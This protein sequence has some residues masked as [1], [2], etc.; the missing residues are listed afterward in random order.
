MRHR[1][2][3]ILALLAL[4]FA[5][6]AY[7]T[8]VCSADWS[9]TDASNNVASPR[10]FPE[11]MAPSGVNDSARA[12]MGAVKRF[13]NR[14][15]GVKTTGGTA[16]AQT[17]TYDVAAAAYCTGERFTFKA[18]AT[19]TGS[20][21]LNVNSLGAKT[22]KTNAGDALVSGE[23][24]SGSYY[25]VVYDGTDMILDSVAA[26]YERGTFTPTVTMGSGSVTLG[27]AAGRFIR[28]GN[29]IHAW[30]NLAASGISTP[31]GTT[32]IGAFPYAAKNADGSEGACAVWTEDFNGLG[33]DGD[34]VVYMIKNTA[35][36]LLQGTTN[37]GANGNITWKASTKVRLTCVYE[38]DS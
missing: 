32:T 12:V 2:L 19:N 33:T 3:S 13:W 18:G 14:N 30:I 7:A 8:D 15:N 28:V 23:I 11:G 24:Q 17:L 36:A 29:L 21:T 22:I 5:V 31:T 20:A 9:E 27:T 26:F 38:T 25:T 4:L 6:P 1:L 37:N 10:G 34:V 16:N 35:T